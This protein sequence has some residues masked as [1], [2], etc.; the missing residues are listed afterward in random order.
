M[1]LLALSCI[2]L[3]YLQSVSAQTKTRFTAAKTKTI[4]LKQAN[5][6]DWNVL[7]QQMEAPSPDG[8]SYRSF[9]LRKQLEIEEKYPKNHIPT[10]KRTITAT[11]TIGV[12]KSFRTNI[13]PHGVPNDN[14]MAISN[15]GI[16]VSAYNS[17]IYVYDT[18]A[19]TAMGEVSLDFF[20]NQI[21]LSARSFD[22]KMVYD[23]DQDRFILVFLIGNTD[24]NSDIITCFSSTNN[25]M[26]AW[27]VYRVP[28]NPLN[29]TSWSDYP[30]ISITKKD[31]F[32]TMNLLLVG[33]PWQT[34]F[35][36]TVIWQINKAEGYAG[37]TA[38]VMDLFTDIK[39]GGLNIRNLHPVRGGFDIKGPNQY[40]LSNRN[41]ANQSD[42]IYLV[43]ITNSLESGNSSLNVTLLKTDQDYYL[44]S[45]AK[46]KQGNFLFFQTNDSRVLG[47]II[48]NNRIEFVQNTLHP[49]T[50]NTA[51]F[52][53]VIPD[54]KKPSITS[55]FIFQDSLELGYPNIV[56]GS[57]IPNE[58]KSIIGFNHAG[59]YHYPGHSAIYYDGNNYS[60]LKMVKEG[61]NVVDAQYGANQRWGDYLGIQRKYNEPCRIWMTGYYGA[62]DEDNGSWASEL[63]APGDC[64]IPQQS[65]Q[66]SGKIF[67]NP[68]VDFSEIHF[69]LTETQN[70]I[71]DLINRDGALVKRLYKAKAKK[72]ENRLT[73]STQQLSEGLYFVRIYSDTSI[74]LTKKI[75][76]N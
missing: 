47:G 7:V 59:L 67:P 33:R 75:V 72:G 41:F 70:I 29:D 73:F 46:Q 23:P 74:I 42:S 56:Y 51:V 50:G 49:P 58:K 4:S 43:E 11:D 30:A 20:R 68:T 6:F 36:Q 35:K 64:F 32:I 38:I 1:R 3:F 53:G 16:L 26:D 5:E 63:Y 40:F 24:Q 18:E 2:F 76:K 44:A 22:P 60:K 34:A 8:D 62:A 61:V 65:K 10:G 21:G 45:R 19:D 17:A 14:S 52:H 37:D 15:D 31:L 13:N 71:I 28:G 9:I 54:V 12:G 55:N 48:E 66:Q 25:P 39:E 27:N 57:N 69:E